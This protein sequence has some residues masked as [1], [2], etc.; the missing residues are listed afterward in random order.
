MP[1]Q[2]AKYLILDTEA[3]GL[4][5]GKHG[6]IQLACVS[7]DDRLQVIHSLCTDIRPPAE[8]VINP[9]ALEINGF[10]EERIA[11]GISYQETAQLFLGFLNQEFPEEEPV[12]VAQFY[13]FDFAALLELCKQTG[14]VG[15]KIHQKL[16]NNLIDTKALTNVLN[17]K[18]VFLNKPIPFPVASL[19]KPGGVKDVLGIAGYQAH[20]AM[21]DVMATREILL[22][23]LERF[24]IQD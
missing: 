6:L 19:S 17:L 11:Q 14:E 20:D 24:E 23:L 10:T 18:H 16:G 9:E 13:P 4:I 22:K 12:V 21:G 15:E 5:P 3:T 8:V 7:T 1:K 2:K